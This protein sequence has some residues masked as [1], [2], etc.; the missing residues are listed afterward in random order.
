MEIYLDLRDKIEDRIEEIENYYELNFDKPNSQYFEKGRMK[1]KKLLMY[2]PSAVS[3]MNLGGNNQKNLALIVNETN[4]NTIESN[5]SNNNNINIINYENKED[6]LN[7]SM[8]QNS[9]RTKK[10]KVKFIPLKEKKWKKQRSVEEF[11][12]NKKIEEEN[13]EYYKDITF[14][15]LD[16]KKKNNNI[17]INKQSNLY[18]NKNYNLYGGYKKNNVLNKFIKQKSDDGKGQKK[19]YIERNFKIYNQNKSS[20]SQEKSFNSKEY[21]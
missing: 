17:F 16:N 11:R 1:L 7:K 21:E 14:K 18:I 4:K 3:E 10:G 19:F 12:P 13:N 8:H 2:E 6:I 5:F 9:H 15:K 20:K